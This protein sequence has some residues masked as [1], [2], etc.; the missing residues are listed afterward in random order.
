MKKYLSSILISLSIVSAGALALVSAS[1]AL[2]WSVFDQGCNGGGSGSGGSAGQ[3]C[4]A[5]QSETADKFP[6]YI[7]NIINTMIFVVGIIAVIMIV[8]GGVRYVVSNGESAQL[9]AAKDTVTYSVIGLVVAILA[10]AV[11][12][13]VL[14]QF[15]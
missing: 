9:K 14:D 3:I 6:E 5:G 7:K 15:R 12:N 1:P 11:V 13:F 8:V 4:G 10:Y 2:A